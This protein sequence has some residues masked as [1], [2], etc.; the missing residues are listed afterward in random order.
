M[1]VPI[2]AVA[3]RLPLREPDLPELLLA[4]RLVTALFRWLRRDLHDLRPEGGK[5]RAASDF[6]PLLAI[7]EAFAFQEET[8]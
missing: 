8:R 6:G 5:T 3:I 2:L 4:I 7:T 1:I